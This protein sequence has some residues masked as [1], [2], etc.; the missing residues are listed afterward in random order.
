MKSERSKLRYDQQEHQLTNE[1]TNA[2]AQEF[3]TV[4]DLLRND[5]EQNPVPGGV[6]ERLNLSIAN[7]PKAPKSWFKSLFR[8]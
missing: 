7:E 1:T 8:L 4:E 6:A 5:S 2:Q 3:A